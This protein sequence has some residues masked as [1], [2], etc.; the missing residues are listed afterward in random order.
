SAGVRYYNA[1]GL[2]A[3]TTY[4][5][6]TR[7]VD[8]L[9]NVNATWKNHTA[10]TAPLPD[11]TA[12]ASVTGLTNITYSQTYINWTWTDPADIDFNHVE[13]YLDGIQKP[14]V[15]PGVRFYNATGLTA[16]TIH[17]IST[18][19]VDNSGN[20]NATW[21]NH[22]ARTAPLP[23]TTAPS[24]AD[25]TPTG[26]NVPVTTQ[27][28]LTFSE[29]MNEASV[30][31]AFS[32]PAT[33]GSFSWIGNFMTYTPD[34]NLT[35]STTYDVTVGTGAMD[36]AGNPLSSTYS[37]LFTT[38][39]S[40]S[41]NTPPGI[42]VHVDPHPD[43]SVEFSDVI[44][45]GYTSVTI[46]TTNPGSERSGFRFLGTYYDIITTAAYTGPITICLNYDD[47]GLSAGRERNLRIQHWTISWEDVTIT[48]Y[49][50]I[51]N[52][53]I[54]GTVSS[55]SWLG[56]AESLPA[57]R[58]INGTVKDNFTGDSLVGVTVSAN[59]TLSTMTNATGFYSFAVI[60]GSYDLTAT[61][62]IRY[63]TNIT[64]VSTIGEA[65]VWQDIKLLKKP[66]GNI[67]GSVTRI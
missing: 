6:G 37:W 13:I 10:R 2:T 55:L 64:T 45:A 25:N 29:P 4:E 21:K 22:T 30:E 56:I 17:E 51:D 24:I 48:G 33:T 20:V 18:R 38:E 46:S 52:N 8:N 35:Y 57:V 58:Y 16:S 53:I 54:C 49:P 7:T 27:I 11:N 44:G 32:M 60:D 63:Y 5:I 36:L 34:S 1:T 65:V 14:N 15:L 47:T 43:V 62:D 67:T 3:S 40:P 9:G 42:N 59:S 31:S 66:I 19:T 12:P 39:A 61:F 41:Q 23:D 28:T 50:D 26:T